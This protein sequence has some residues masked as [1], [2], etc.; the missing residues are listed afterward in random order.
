M[1]LLALPGDGIGPEITA[2]TLRVLA[3]VDARFGLGLQIE[4]ADIGLKSLA[5]NCSAKVCHGSGGIVLLRAEQNF[6]TLALFW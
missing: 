1:R 6:A 5:E 2:A 3:A 4:T